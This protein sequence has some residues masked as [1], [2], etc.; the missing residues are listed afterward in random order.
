MRLIRLNNTIPDSVLHVVISISIRKAPPPPPPVPM[1]SKSPL[2]A[3][4]SSPTS[5]QS[6]PPANL[7][8]AIRNHKGVDGLKKADTHM[9]IK[10]KSFDDELAA[11]I[12][13]QRRAVGGE[14]RDG[15]TMTRSLSNM[16]PEPELEADTPSFFEDSSEGRFCQ[17]IIQPAREARGPE[18][19]AR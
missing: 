11:R 4:K 3:S 8:D 1:T 13:L 9:P 10:S 17:N 7:L 15:K 14:E 2:T 6:H 19:P 5:T 18:G 16:I 12:A